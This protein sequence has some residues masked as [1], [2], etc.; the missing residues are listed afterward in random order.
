MNEKLIRLNKETVVA[1]KWSYPSVFMDDHN[2]ENVIKK[3]EHIAARG[4]YV[5]SNPNRPFDDFFEILMKSS[6]EAKELAE[7]EDFM[8]SVYMNVCV[9]WITNPD[10][11]FE[12]TESEI[13]TLNHEIKK[14]RGDIPKR[15]TIYDLYTKF[16]GKIEVTI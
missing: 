6:S 8:M 16:E 11:K 5:T 4:G 15:V 9:E 12:L 14:I 2:Y 13:E 3:L 1:I 10:A 7:S